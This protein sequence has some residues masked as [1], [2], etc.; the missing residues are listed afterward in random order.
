MSYI[1]LNDGIHMDKINPYTNPDPNKF[2]PGVSEGGAYKTVYV[3][4][5]PEATLVNSVK[6]Y[7]DALGGALAAQ[8]TEASPG[9]METTAAGWRTPYYCTPGSQDYPLNRPAVPERIYDNPPWNNPTAVP[10]TAPAKVEKKN[11][12]LVRGLQVVAAVLL[13]LSV[14]YF[15]KL[16]P[17]N[18][19]V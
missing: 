9:C 4:S 8:E 2:N 16:L 15:L 5:K 7:E 1:H 14:L 19:R 6:P 17:L 10:V 18:F 13:L 3:G 12:N 11:T